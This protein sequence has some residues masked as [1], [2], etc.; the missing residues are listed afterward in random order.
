MPNEAPRLSR[1]TGWRQLVIGLIVVAALVLTWTGSLDGRANGYVSSALSRAMVTFATAR[2]ANALISVAKSTTITIP[3]VGGV[4]ASPGQILEPLD[5]LIAE[6]SAL[7]LAAS[8]SLA[9]QKLLISLGALPSVCVA[10]SVGV[11]AWGVL[12]AAFRGSPLWLARA[13]TI[14]LFIRFAVPV[15]ALTSE[16]AYD[17]V[18]ST[19]YENAQSQVEHSSRSF[20]DH[21][22]NLRDSAAKLKDPVAAWNELKDS[23]EAQVRH[24]VTLMAIFVLQ[25]II[26]PLLFLWVAY[27]LL[28]ATFT[29]PRAVNWPRPVAS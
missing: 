10:V 8:M 16:A 23:V 3:F 9:A 21:L 18:M 24:V 17:A 28:G 20:G 15:A 11:V 7:M 1:S 26:L 25:T 2:T 27:R 6:F 19:P 29:W 4:S 22:T 13:V 14:L 12:Q 5:E